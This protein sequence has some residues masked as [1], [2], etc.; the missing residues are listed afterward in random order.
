[1]VLGGKAEEV[2]DPLL[3]PSQQEV[4]VDDLRHDGEA[5]HLQRDGEVKDSNSAAMQQV[6]NRKSNRDFE[7]TIK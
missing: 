1:M 2:E 4:G 7:V 5:E 6:S 3:V